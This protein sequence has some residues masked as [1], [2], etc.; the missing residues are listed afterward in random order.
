MKMPRDGRT[1]DIYTGEP[2]GPSRDLCLLYVMIGVPAIAVSILFAFFTD[3]PLW[4]AGTASIPAVF[5]CYLLLLLCLRT[6][7]TFRTR[8]RSKSGAT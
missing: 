6:I 7:H 8:K 1:T 2:S 4:I 3:L 5:S